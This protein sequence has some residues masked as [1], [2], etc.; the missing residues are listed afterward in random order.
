M[1]NV[2]KCYEAV[3]GA[4]GKVITSKMAVAATVAKYPDVNPGSIL[5]SDYAG[6][7]QKSG[8]V[9]ADQIFERVPG[10]FLVLPKSKH[11]KKPS[12]RGTRG[13]SLADAFKSF[14]AL[15]TPANGKQTAPAS[16]VVIVPKAGT[17][18]G[19]GIAQAQA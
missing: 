10:G 6:P 17:S 1:T 2:E 8:T 7:N 11:V 15:L 12:T 18:K 19:N 16:N 14:Q 3:K 5:P 4:E 9:Y 13:E